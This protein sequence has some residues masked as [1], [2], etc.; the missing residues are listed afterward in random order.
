MATTRFI[1]M[2]IGRGKS[3]AESI[4]GRT[5]YAENPDKTDGGRLVT[6]FGCNARIVDAEFLLA[7]RQYAA[8]TGRQIRKHDVLAYQIR[9]S[10][11]PGE[12]T[13]EEAN[14]IGYELAIRFTK[15]KHAFIVATHIDKAHIFTTIL[16]LIPLH[17]IAPGNSGIFLAPAKPFED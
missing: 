5:D 2:H 6:S 15:D 16:F 14:K 7:K 1:S 9:Q 17:W 10:F 12:V 8:I 13:P 3:V 11:K 4:R